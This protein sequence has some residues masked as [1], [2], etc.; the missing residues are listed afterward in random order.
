MNV[1]ER[2][3]PPVIGQVSGAFAMRNMTNMV[4]TAVC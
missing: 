3:E 2:Y 4:N 1:I